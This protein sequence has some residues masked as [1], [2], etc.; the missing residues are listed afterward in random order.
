MVNCPKCKAE[1]L[2]SATNCKSCQINLANALSHPELF[3]PEKVQERYME[4]PKSFFQSLF[5]FSFTVLITSKIIKVLY[6]LSIAGAAIVSIFLI[7]Y[8]F[9]LSTTVGVL[10]LIIGGPLL[11]V[12]TIIYSRVFLEI[13]IVIFRI[14][15]HASEIA[16]QGRKG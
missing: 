11:F 10:M 5:D 3:G 8:G 9:K 16:A 14:S 6:G 2:D 7:I 15:E 12:L 13:M 4:Q 1:N